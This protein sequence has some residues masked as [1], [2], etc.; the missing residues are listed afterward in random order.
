[1]TINVTIENN[2][3]PYDDITD[4]S[5]L[6][7]HTKEEYTE[8]YTASVIQVDETGVNEPR[9][10]MNLAPGQSYNTAIWRGTSLK[11]SE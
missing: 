5:Y 1:M 6:S 11:I 3:M 4:E 10:L 8:N 2:T 9:V 7:I